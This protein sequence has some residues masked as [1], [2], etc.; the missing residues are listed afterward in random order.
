MHREAILDVADV[1]GI[2]GDALAIDQHEAAVGGPCAEANCEQFRSFHAGDADGQRL[3]GV[4]DLDVAHLGDFGQGRSAGEALGAAPDGPPPAINSL[5]AGLR[6]P[7]LAT[8]SPRAGVSVIPDFSATA[9]R[10]RPK[11]AQTTATNA[12]ASAA[13]GAVGSTPV[14]AAQPFHAAEFAAIA[15]DDNEPAAARVACDQHVVA[16]D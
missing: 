12:T 14:L 10:R 13:V 2:D 3:I 16:A 4:C 6:W 1:C 15:G 5:A 7:A 9:A 11:S 8:F